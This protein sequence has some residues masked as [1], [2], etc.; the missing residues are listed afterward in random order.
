[1][2]AGGL[3]DCFKLQDN[4]TVSFSLYVV[5]DIVRLG[6]PS[7]E[8]VQIQKIYNN[9]H[10]AKSVL[11]NCD[12]S[13]PLINCIGPVFISVKWNS[14]GSNFLSCLSDAK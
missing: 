13:N 11:A 7:G 1:M 8:S 5:D 9:K 10:N 4:D 2:L 3:P 12:K 6:T 14:W